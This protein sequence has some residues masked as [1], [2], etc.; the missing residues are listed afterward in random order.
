MC[1]FQNEHKS[2]VILSYL[3]VTSH[4]YDIINKI[5]R[6]DL[7]QNISKEFKKQQKA[8]SFIIAK[9]AA[10]KIYYYITVSP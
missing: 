6:Q 7:R 1:F 8:A 10:F 3:V 9:D 4:D 2:P 5:Y